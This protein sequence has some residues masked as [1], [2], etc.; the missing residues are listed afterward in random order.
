MSKNVI[1][2]MMSA[3]EVADIVG[4]T[5]RY[6]FML[7]TEK[8]IE[9]NS[10]G[11]FDTLD[12]IKRLLTHYRKAKASKSELNDVKAEILKRKLAE[13]D[14]ELIPRELQE[15]WQRIVVGMIANT[16]EEAP[17]RYAKMFKEIPLEEAQERLANIFGDKGIKGKLYKV[18]E[19]VKENPRVLKSEEIVDESEL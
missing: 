7:E 10:R 4:V 19:K 5:Q 15:E 2:I 13:M 1:P 17:A 18:F 8:V 9:R 14:G 6:I 11:K 12:T 3:S 16:L